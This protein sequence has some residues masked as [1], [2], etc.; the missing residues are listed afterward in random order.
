MMVFNFGHFLFEIL[1]SLLIFP[2][3]DPLL[4]IDKLP[5]PFQSIIKSIFLP[6]DNKLPTLADLI[7][8]NIFCDISIARMAQREVQMPVDVKQFLERLSTRLVERL[9]QNRKKLVLENKL[10]TVQNLLT[11]S[12]RE[13]FLKRGTTIM[14]SLKLGS[15]NKI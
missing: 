11:K 10:A 3:D 4:A 8:E 7:A 9:N 2:V 14:E 13:R 1:T 5:L 12:D 6:K 15:A